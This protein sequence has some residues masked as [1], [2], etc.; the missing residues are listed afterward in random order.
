MTNSPLV[1]AQNFDF[2][3]AHWRTK[4][5]K[6]C[7]VDRLAKLFLRVGKFHCTESNL[8]IALDT[9]RAM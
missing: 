3:V 9:N 4:A 5:G 7:V 1:D 6:S 2:L 8:H